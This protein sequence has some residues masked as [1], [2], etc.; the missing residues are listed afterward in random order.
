LFAHR[1]H[2]STLI[3]AEAAGDKEKKHNISP[4]ITQR[5]KDSNRRTSENYT[6]LLKNLKKSCAL[7]F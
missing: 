5:P 1:N 2:D 6:V 7:N 3:L 4:G